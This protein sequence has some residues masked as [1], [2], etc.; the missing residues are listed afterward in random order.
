M[1]RNFI[2]LVCM[3]ICLLSACMQS[4]EAVTTMRGETTMGDRE[5]GSYAIIKPTRPVPEEVLPEIEKN[6]GLLLNA[7]PIDDNVA[8]RYA[9]TLYSFFVPE[10][11]EVT[12][13][14]HEDYGYYS[15]EAVGTDSVIYHANATIG[16]LE[17]IFKISKEG[18][19]GEE[20]LFSYAANPS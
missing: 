9:E 11:V 20:M 12:V 2:I 3:L 7:M 4:D 10:L 17:F 15:I 16:G 5:F 13:I 18:E 1:K 6:K 14:I 19:N 8:L